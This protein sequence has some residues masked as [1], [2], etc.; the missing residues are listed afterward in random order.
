MIKFNLYN[1]VNKETGIK[2]KVSYHIGNRSGGRV[3][4]ILDERE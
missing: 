1:V 4:V 2:A 3:C